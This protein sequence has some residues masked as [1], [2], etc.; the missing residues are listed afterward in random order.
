[1]AAGQGALRAGGF[2]EGAAHAR[3]VW[4]RRLNR[5]AVRST[6]GAQHMPSAGRA[7]RTVLYNWRF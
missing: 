2:L 1:M 3:G 4:G 5:G 6:C 7:V